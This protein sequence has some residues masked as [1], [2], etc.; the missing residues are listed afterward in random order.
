MNPYWAGALVETI[1]AIM[2]LLGLAV[3]KKF[4]KRPIYLTCCAILWCGTFTLGTYFYLNK[5]DEL[6]SNYPW[7][8][9]FPNVC[10][11]FIYTARALGIGSINHSLQVNI[12][13]EIT[14]YLSNKGLI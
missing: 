14:R 10:A 3:N 9:W 12:N 8:A 2:S 13:K 7:M 5:N 11:I 4:K 6:T 1:R